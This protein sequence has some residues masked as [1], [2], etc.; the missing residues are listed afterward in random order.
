M[1]KS[2]NKVRAKQW[3][4]E[5]LVAKACIYKYDNE[6][7]KLIFFKDLFIYSW[8]RQSEREVET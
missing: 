7:I 1:S 4:L 5:P 2:R 6:G 3:V 8:E